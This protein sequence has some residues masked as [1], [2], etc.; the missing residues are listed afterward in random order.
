VVPQAANSPVLGSALLEPSQMPSSISQGV[1]TVFTIVDFSS[2]GIS[3]QAG[4][5]LAIV[6]RSNVD[7]NRSGSDSYLWEEATTGTP[8]GW[9]WSRTGGTTGAF[10][11]QPNP[12]SNP[13]LAFEEF[14]QVPEPASSAIVSIGSLLMLRRRRAPLA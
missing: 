14:V 12:T 11:S 7:V 13:N 6:L 2:Q 9:A 8:T 4:V 1:S 10:S 5:P 3:V